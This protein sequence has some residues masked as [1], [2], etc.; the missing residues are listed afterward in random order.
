MGSGRRNGTMHPERQPEGANQSK[1]GGGECGF[2][3]S[4]CSRA[5][6]GPAQ[7][8]CWTGTHT[9][10]FEGRAQMSK[11]L[12]CWTLT[13]P[14]TLP[15][16]FTCPCGSVHKAHGVITHRWRWCISLNLNTAFSLLYFLQR[17]KDVA[18]SWAL[19]DSC[20]LVSQLECYF[21]PISFIWKYLCEQIKH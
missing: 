10:V 9:D 5:S 20:Q 21:N 14:V 3:N 8:S 11:I 16:A 15:P 7:A 6:E 13:L 17:V 19:S 4:A 18:L 2:T 1:L 12:W